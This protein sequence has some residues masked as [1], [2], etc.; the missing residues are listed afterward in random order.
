MLQKGDVEISNAYVIMT[1]E[2][3]DAVDFTAPILSTRYVFVYYELSNDAIN[4]S[5]YISSHAR[6]IRSTSFRIYIRNYVERKRS[7]I[8]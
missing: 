5:D 6:I 8:I 2:R 7:C 3:M 4:I 1:A